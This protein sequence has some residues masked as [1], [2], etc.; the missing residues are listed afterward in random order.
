[1]RDIEDPRT[2]MFSCSMSLF[3]AGCES[4]DCNSGLVIPVESS[5]VLMRGICSLVDEDGV[6][7]RLRDGESMAAADSAEVSI[8]LLY[9]I[10]D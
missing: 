9:C 6:L 8:I 4:L 7:W 10:S 3:L 1:V 5:A 2:G